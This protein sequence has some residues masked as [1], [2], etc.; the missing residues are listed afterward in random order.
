MAIRPSKIICVGRSYADHAKE[1]GNA[2][3]DQ[4]VLFLKPPS[5]LLGLE[6]GIS[7]NPAWGS[8]HV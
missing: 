6:E 4:A 7:W 3:P 5:S 2:V 1:L 8:Y